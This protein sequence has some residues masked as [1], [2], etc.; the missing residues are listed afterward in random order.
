[1]R[2]VRLGWVR[3]FGLI[4][5]WRQ[6]TL[7]PLSACALMYLGRPTTTPV[8]REWYLR[9]AARAAAAYLGDVDG[10]GPPAARC[11]TAPSAAE[12][13]QVSLLCA[14][15]P[16]LRAAAGPRGLGGEVE[17]LV[18]RARLNI[19][20]AADYAALLQRLSDAD[21][22]VRHGLTGSG[23]RRMDPSRVARRRDRR[24]ARPHRH[25]RLAAHGAGPAGA[26]PR[27]APASSVARRRPPPSGHRLGVHG[28]GPCPR[29]GQRPGGH[30]YR[31]I[32]LEQLVAGAADWTSDTCPRR[33]PGERG[34][35]ADGGAGRS[36]L[37]G[38]LGDDRRVGAGAE[39]LA[40]G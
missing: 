19:D 3:E 38:P 36:H 24:T 15:L 33:R 27:R 40:L 11:T 16:A 23:S 20:I 35:G 31:H 10:T 29:G 17:S 4:D 25:G 12:G 1:M 30:G 13:G 26:V 21:E 6:Q 2:D 9:L 28:G 7:L 22:D 37:G 14:N 34:V 18:T 32:S 8:H 5:E 39:F